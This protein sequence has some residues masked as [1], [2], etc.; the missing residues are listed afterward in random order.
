[1]VMF[2][3]PRRAFFAAL[4][5]TVTITGPSFAQA[6]AEWP[7]WGGDLGASKFSSLADVN[8]SNVARLARAWEWTTGETA[9]AETGVRPGNFQA[10]PLMIG[11]TLFLSTS[12]NRVVA[13]D[14]NT[15]REYWSYDPKAYV[16]GQP[17]NGTGFV[18]RGVATWTDGAQRRVFMN[19]RWNLI[20][21]D[22]ATGK[23]IRGFGD[24]GVVDLTRQLRRN[25]KPVDK[26]HYTQTS[27]PV[28]WRDLVIV[29]NGVADRLM[30]ENDP[31]GDVQAFDVKTGRRVWAFS[32]IPTGPR[33]EGADT[34]HDRS[35]MSAG[36]TNVWAPFSVDERRGLVYLPTSTPSNDWYGGARKGNNLFAE[37]LVCLDARTGK[38]V[39]HFQTVRHGLWDYDLPSAPLLA[40][41][42]IDGRARDIVALPTK[43]G[44]LFVFDRTDGKPIWPIVDRAVPGSDVP[45]EAAASSQPFPTKP[46]PFARQG[47]SFND[48]VDFTPAIRAR[49]LD[50]IQGYR[51]GPLYTPPSLAG[52]L[53][54]PGV[55][56]GA[57]WGGGAFDPSTN[58]IFIKATNQAALFKIV[59]PRQTDVLRAEYTADL[60]AQ[61]P[62]V[63]IPAADS[64]QRPLSLPINK[65]PYGT[66]VAID[67][68][69]G[70][71]R[72]NITLGDTPA[73]RDHPALRGLNLPPLGVAGSPGP[74]VTAGG[75]VFLTGGGSTLYAIDSQ[76]GAT[77]WSA[78]LEQAGFAVPATYR[79]K[80]ENSSW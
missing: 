14:A 19:T 50:A 11:D 39:W 6:G 58:T 80:R 71:E 35:W 44:F 40:T 43:Q 69:T 34:W 65:P 37:T 23:P 41:V 52:T 9:N 45:G 1:M 21:L 3:L 30:Y 63:T 47:F 77:H 15:G 61:S 12:Y 51:L 56:G 60:S 13:L 27:P 76:T 72:W 5:L 25:G 79:P 8:R 57:G 10:T 78:D 4:G 55:I 36:H 28:V 29:G 16:A 46:K 48:L 74:I 68:S 22:A 7:V 75:L 18:H 49:A 73:I 62:R 59:Q 24:T 38:K 64:T 31:P 32:P 20:A 70:D 2:T 54:L 66:L 53:V 26:L 33:D 42:K 67:L 17:P